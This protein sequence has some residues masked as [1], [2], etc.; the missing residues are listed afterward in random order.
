[1]EITAKANAAATK[2]NAEANAEA[3]TK[4]G[5]AEAGVILAKG[6]STAEAYKLEVAAMSKEVFGQIRVIEKIASN[7]L[8]LIP[9]NLVVGGGSEK[10]GLMDGFFGV[11]LL[12]K[13]TGRSFA[14]SSSA[15]EEKVEERKQ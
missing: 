6:K 15:V 8:K 11:A 14:A 7:H 10:G 1:M 2:V 3:T 4:V 5:N 9:E 13:L 12:E